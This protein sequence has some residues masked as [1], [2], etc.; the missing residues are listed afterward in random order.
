MLTIYRQLSR[1]IRNDIASV[2]DGV[3]QI[4]NGAAQLQLNRN[5]ME[6]NLVVLAFPHYNH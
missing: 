1:A 3:H 5:R 6:S 4:S 2:Y